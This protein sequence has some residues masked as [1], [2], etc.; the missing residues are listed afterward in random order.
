LVSLSRADAASRF[1]CFTLT[2]KY[3]LRDGYLLHH[4]RA[5]RLGSDAASAITAPQSIPLTYRA[6]RILA[7]RTAAEL[8][9]LGIGRNCRVTIVLPNGPEMA[10]AFIMISAVATAAPL[11]P[12]YK[13]SE[14]QFH[15]MDL[16]AQAL[17]VEA[18]AKML[19]PSP[20]DGS[21][22]ATRASSTTKAI[23]V[24]RAG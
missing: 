10:A 21:A 19:P 20:K 11:N 12:A 8:N 1:W 7:A 22:R 9:R 17:I 5:G 3:D 2:P 23:C 15:L 16:K 18:G 13:E 14:F 4:R 6:L 24:L